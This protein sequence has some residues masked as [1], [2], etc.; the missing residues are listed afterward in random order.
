MTANDFAVSDTEWDLLLK[1]LYLEDAVRKALDESNPSIVANYA[2]DVAKK[3]NTFYHECSVL[4][5]PSQEIVT[6]RLNFCLATHRV[7]KTSLFLLGIEV[8]ER[9]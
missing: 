3:F 9:M 7:I 8:P 1:L 2:L 4:Q 6:L 5:A